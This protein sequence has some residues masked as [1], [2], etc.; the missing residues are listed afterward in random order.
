VLIYLAN[1]ISGLDLSP[2]QL[3]VDSA[4]FA[5]EIPQGYQW[6]ALIF[7]LNDVVTPVTGNF[8]TTSDGSFRTTSDGSF[9][10]V[11]P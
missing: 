6:Q 2:E 3:Q 7:F 5:R 4:C 11:S 10:I 9:R 8:R 1:Q